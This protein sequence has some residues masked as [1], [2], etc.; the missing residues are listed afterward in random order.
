MRRLLLA[1][2]SIAL[3]V[4]A[5]VLVHGQSTA[6]ELTE[7]LQR[8]VTMLYHQGWV[9]AAWPVENGLRLAAHQGPL[10]TVPIGSSAGVN[11]TSSKTSAGSGPIGWDAWLR[12]GVETRW[13]QLHASTRHA[14]QV[15][16]LVGVELWLVPI[17]IL[18]VLA[19]PLWT[20]TARLGRLRPGTGHGTARFAGASELRQ[21]RPR[22]RE[23]GLW[24][25]RVGRRPVVLPE[26]EVYEHILVCGPPGSGKSSGLILPNLLIERGTRS[27]VIV[28][29][30]SELLEVTRRAIER[31]SEVWVVNFL[32]PE[33]SHGY[34]PLALV[35]SYLAAEGFAEC[36]ITNTGRSSRDPFW[37]NAAK[38]LIVAAVLHLRAER[39]GPPPTLA[40]LASFFTGH[41]AETITAILGASNSPHARDCA[42]SFLSSMNKNEKLL[43]S[44]FSELPPRFS[45]LQDERVRQST[46]RHQVQFAR[47]GQR[48]GRPVALYLALE[49]TMAPLLK[50]LSACFF[51][52]LFEELIRVADAS[53]GGLLP[54]PVL[55]YADEFGNIGEI[56]DMARWM[57]TV[58]SAR[59][60]FL[61]AVQDLAQLG[62][63]YGKEGRQIIVTDCSTKIA[64]A[65]TSADDAEWFSRGTGTATVLA[66]S[67]GD[68][69]KRGDQL[70]R[71]GSR[72]VSEIARPLLTPG[73]VTRLPE[74]TM[75]VLAGN[76]Q[77]VLV[78]QRRWYQD[79]RLRRQGGARAESDA[80]RARAGRVAATRLA[81]SS[82]DDATAKPI[83]TVVP[84]PANMSAAPNDDVVQLDH[85]YP[86]GAATWVQAPADTTDVVAPPGQLATPNDE[87]TIAAAAVAVSAF[88]LPRDR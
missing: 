80:P 79:R 68:S 9:A 37:D 3:P 43:G 30:K 8:R 38:Q 73:E 69:R 77:P 46:S 18:V 75:L 49:R 41:D 13:R 10:L 56:P 31:H 78:T 5:L 51:M 22:R 84:K 85:M 28:D 87:P 40:D 25:G 35:D 45:I 29:P 63:I 72:G 54:R 19:K 36:W 12:P 17:L 65:K 39:S 53:P 83:P 2:A 21:L 66:Y 82:Q 1:G 34:N 44:V 15:R 4:A 11:R 32:D 76:R 7:G 62:A 33:H 64:L 50:P 71:S 74:D 52:Q 42:R 59:I 81:N 67:A 88:E 26:S 14:A 6:R 61:L 57:S 48:D 60:G 47:L 70:A 16:A 58:R 55:G 20:L 24:L 86:A 23:A 27:L